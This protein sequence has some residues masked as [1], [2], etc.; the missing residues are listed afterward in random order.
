VMQ[1]YSLVWSLMRF[2]L[3]DQRFAHGLVCSPYLASFR[4]YLMMDTLALGYILHLAGRI[5]N[6]HRLETYIAKCTS[7]A[8]SPASGLMVPYGAMDTFS[9]KVGLANLSFV[10]GRRLKNSFPSLIVDF[11]A[12]AFVLFFH[13]LLYRFLI[14]I[15]NSLAV[16]PSRLEITIVS[17]TIFRMSVEYHQLVLSFYPSYRYRNTLLRWNRYIHMNMIQ[18]RFSLIIIAYSILH[19]FPNISPIPFQRYPIIA[20]RQYFGMKTICYVQLYQLY[21]KLCHSFRMSPQDFV[22]FT[23]PALIV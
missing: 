22:R 7:Q 4:F 13:I 2:L 23:K 18:H 1:P 3:S 16:I 5:P 17:F 11:H 21:A 20:L 10:T 12:I 15:I 19:T 8:T 14:Y 9:L 6:F